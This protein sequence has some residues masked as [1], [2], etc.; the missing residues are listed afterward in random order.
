MK[1]QACLEEILPW[2]AISISWLWQGDKI[3]AYILEKQGIKR[4][5]AFKVS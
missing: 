4:I 2:M 5:V 1:L 3:F